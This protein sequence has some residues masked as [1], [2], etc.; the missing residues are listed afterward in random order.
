MEQETHTLSLYIYIYIYADIECNDT[1]F[2]RDMYA[3]NLLLAPRGQTFGRWTRKVTRLQRRLE[4][5]MGHCSKLH[6]ECSQEEWDISVSFMEPFPLLFLSLCRTSKRSRK[7]CT[8]PGHTPE[9]YKDVL[10]E[11]IRLKAGKPGQL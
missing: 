4:G 10:A 5:I 1:G 9:M 2:I 6:S 11:G 8:T 7:R 3:H